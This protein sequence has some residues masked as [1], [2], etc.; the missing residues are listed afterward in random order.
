MISNLACDFNNTNESWRSMYPANHY[1]VITLICHFELSSTFNFEQPKRPFLPANC[2]D[3]PGIIHTHMAGMKR[4]NP[5]DSNWHFLTF[6][7]EERRRSVS[8]NHRNAKNGI[9]RTQMNQNCNEKKGRSTKFSRITHHIPSTN[10]GERIKA[11]TSWS[12][13]SIHRALKSSLPRQRGLS[14][15]IF[16]SR[17]RAFF[18]V[19]LV[20]RIEKAGNAS[21]TLALNL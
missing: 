20:R 4:K 17:N 11:F 16:P 21:T 12:P 19:G 9:S 7:N 8:M 18:F 2:I 14:T 3:K 1:R 15:I 13:F 10:N 6:E 5:N